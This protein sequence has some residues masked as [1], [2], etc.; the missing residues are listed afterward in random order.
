MKK[1]LLAILLSAPAIF[2]ACEKKEKEK[3]ENACP[4]VA[5]SAVPQAVKDS[6]AMRYPATTVTTWF[7]KDS[8]AFCAYFVTAANEEKLVEFANSGSF[9]KEEIETHQEGQH[10][11]STAAVS[12]GNGCQCEVNKEGD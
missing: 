5:A 11:D 1:V 9:I 4:I 7:N 6:F 2:V 12:K 10:E 3:D 8:E